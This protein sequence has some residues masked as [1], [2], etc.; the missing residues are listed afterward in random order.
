MGVV[1]TQFPRFSE[2]YGHYKETGIGL[3]C[4]EAARIILED[5]K[6]FHIVERTIDEEEFEDEEYDGL[7]CKG[8]EKVRNCLFDVMNSD[9]EFADKLSVLLDTGEYI[10]ELINRNDYKAI[11]EYV[12]R[13]VN[14]EALPYEEADIMEIWDTYDS[15][16]VLN[17][18]WTEF[19]KDLTASLHKDDYVRN[20]SGFNKENYP[21]TGYDKLV[22]YYLFRYLLQSV[23]DHDFA[24]KIYFMTANLI[25]IK[26]MDIYIYKRDGMLTKEQHMECIHMFS[27][28]IEYSTDNLDTLSEEFLFS[29]IFCKERLES[30]VRTLF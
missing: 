6:P 7:L 26:E 8:I 14:R 12:P 13:Y 23:Y 9:M 21:F 27:R 24:G 25:L 30:I 29:D 5:T 3:A 20:L 18:E 15:M 10:Q 11:L 28:E 17:V 19:V 1:C 16:E 22:C 4:E 2:Y